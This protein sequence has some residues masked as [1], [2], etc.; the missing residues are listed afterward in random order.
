MKK[1]ILCDICG[2]GITEEI[3][4]TKSIPTNEIAIRFDLPEKI[5]ALGQVTLPIK[6]NV[7]WWCL[8]S[9]IEFAHAANKLVRSGEC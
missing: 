6:K 1:A 3:D 5:D 2:G 7:C 4:Q 9:A 8:L